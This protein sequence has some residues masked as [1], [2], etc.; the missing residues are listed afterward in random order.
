MFKTVMKH[1]FPSIKG[2]NTAN[3]FYFEDAN[4]STEAI[5]QEAIAELQS[6]NADKPLNLVSA[7]ER[8]QQD[9]YDF[10]FGESLATIQ[11]D[12]LSLYVA[13]KV[14][15]LLKTPQSMLNVMPVLPASLTKV[16]EQLSGD[17]FDIEDLLSLIRQE[18]SIAAKVIELSNSSFYNHANKEITDLKS[19]FM[20]LGRNGLIEGVINGFISKMTPQSK[21]YFK[22]YGNKIWQHSLETGVIAKALINKSVHKEEGGQGYLIGLICNLGDMIIYQLLM[23]AFSFVH[24]DSQPNSYAFKTVMQKNS[25]KLT[26]HI[27]KHWQFPPSILDALALQV[28]LTKSSMLPTVFS[29]RPIACYVYEAN[30]ISELSMMF[31][32][33]DKTEKEINERVNTLLYSDEAKQYIETL[34]TENNP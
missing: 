27:A 28:K 10:L 23:E 7:E 9:F 1:L 34:F 22:Q 6:I 17:D 32:Y 21:I 31:D 3:Y 20:L 18:P 4:K 24:P 16:I 30:I 15:A 14:Q 33:K 29:K 8:Q 2:K 12:E 26:Y 11:H 25:N 13:D 5:Q 19:A